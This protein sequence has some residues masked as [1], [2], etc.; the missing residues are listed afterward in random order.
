MIP[1]ITPEAARAA[2]ARASVSV[3]ELIERAGRAVA[4]HAIDMLGGTYGRTV[5]V[6]EGPGNNGADGVVA[7]AA[8]RSA[9]CAVREVNVA[10]MPRDLRDVVSA[11]HGPIDLCIDAAY[12]TGHRGSWQPPEVGDTRVL[13][14]DLPSGVN[15]MTGEVSAALRADR[16][17][18][19]QAVKPGLIFGDGPR[20]A[21]EIVVA[22]LGL[23]IGRPYASIVE[24]GDVASWL[25]TRMRDSHKW[26]SAVRVIAGSPGMIG[27]GRLATSAAL[28]SGAG[29]V[30]WSAPGCSIEDSDEV[31]HVLVERG[32]WSQRVLDSAGR[33]RSAIVGPGLGRADDT[34]REVMTM[35]HS[36]DSALVIDGDGLFALTWNA[37]GSPRSLRRR[38]SPTVLT[39]HDGEYRQLLGEDPVGDRIAAANLL[40]AESGA[41][42]LLK[43]PNT[44]IADPDGR[45]WVVTN[46]DER[47]ATAGSGDVLS[48]IIGAFLA[49]GMP[50]W[51]AA[52]S[53]A[54]VHAE[55][56]GA[57]GLAGVIASDLVDALPSVLARLERDR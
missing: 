39:P 43:G 1:V 10:H 49:M 45:S 5:V 23:D 40:V 35:A 22:D 31:V 51:A 4:H 37:E 18:T 11:S 54:W 6:I 32:C 47:L 56:A 52:A 41:T 27:A 13:A 33:F 50:A 12:G 30:H 44:V 3:A 2:D 8:L 7:A 25:P 42:V 34:A 9:G 20:Y 46:G 17:V 21:G 14:V 36:L 16:T 26:T 53:A 55:C 15:P 48:G 29:M 38:T 28:R 57:V 24:A 19:F